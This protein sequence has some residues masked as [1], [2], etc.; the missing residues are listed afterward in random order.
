MDTNTDPDD[1]ATR[2]RALSDAELRARCGSGTLNEAAQTVANKELAARGLERPGPV[3]ATDDGAA[4]D[5]LTVAQFLNPTD[6]YI[7]SAAL[8]AAGIPAVVA[9]ANTVQMN[10]LWAS[11]VGGVRVRVRAGRAAEARELIEA[12]NRGELALPD[13]REPQ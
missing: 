9:D 3:Q 11:A 10:Q 5:F 1:L 6:A 13:D 2:F 8:E 4:G 12:F 7:V